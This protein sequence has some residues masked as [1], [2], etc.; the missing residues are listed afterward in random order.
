M[1]PGWGAHM[2][3]GA[4]RFW[5]RYAPILSETGVLT[6]ADLPALRVLCE[7][8]S[9]WTRY[10]NMLNKGKLDPV[11]LPRYE[12]MT[13]TVES[14]MRLYLNEFGMTGSSRGK[15]TTNGHQEEEPDYLD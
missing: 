7:L 14:Q 10:I 6:E 13:N 4:K 2:S 5:K 9:R 15:I 11:L 8:W 3:D 1:P 12:K